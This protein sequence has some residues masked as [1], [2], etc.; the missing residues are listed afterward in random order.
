MIYVSSSCVKTVRINE[1]VKALAEAGFKHIELSGGTEA[2]D[3]LES[4]LLRLQEK[5]EL[6]YLCHNYFPPPQKAFVLNLAAL[7]ETADL[8]L[9]HCKRAIDLSMRLGAQQFAFHAGFLINIPLD[10][11]GKK[12][13]KRTLFDK[14]AAL[15][16]FHEMLDQLLEYADGKVKLYIENNVLSKEN[17]LEFEGEN[18][19]FFTHS[20]SLAEA[21]GSC[22]IGH[23]LDLA[24]LRVSANSLNLD[25]Q[26]EVNRLIDQ[27]D[28]I[29]ISE[30][31]GKRDE[32]KALK[33]DSAIVNALKNKKLK[34]KS[35]TL[36]TYTDLRGIRESYEIVQS[37]L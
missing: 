12:I 27:T 10:Q 17:H 5:Y 23:L 14:S 32:N 28:Y 37:L 19:F 3:N 25:F 33:V 18:P 8:S 4:D 29:H 31:Q 2:Y 16:R 13:E 26:N 20:D 22:E 15:K 30:N 36:E 1:S 34:H 9:A 6:Q 35:I 21:K 11:I 7:D 24:H